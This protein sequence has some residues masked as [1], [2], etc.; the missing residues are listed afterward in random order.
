MKQ[1]GWINVDPSHFNQR[2]IDSMMRV[3]GNFGITFHGGLEH[4][5][6]HIQ[7]RCTQHFNNH[8]INNLHFL[9]GTK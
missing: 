5:F 4:E 9:W 1:N 3:Q 7:G 8:N 6:L 2:P